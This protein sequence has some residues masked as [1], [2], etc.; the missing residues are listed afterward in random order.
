ME[1]E[2]AKPPQETSGVCGGPWAAEGRF[3]YRGKDPGYKDLD[4]GYKDLDPGC[5]DLDP[6]YKDLDPGYCS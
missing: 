3:T 4:P 5:K 6:G 1:F 2:G